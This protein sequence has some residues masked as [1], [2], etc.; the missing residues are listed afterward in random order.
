MF[1]VGW[2]WRTLP[3]AFLLAATLP[4]REMLPLAA[5]CTGSRRLHA[6]LV[7]VLLLLL[8]GESLVL[9]PPFLH[10]LASLVIRKSS[11]WS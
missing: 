11:D 3:A 10:Q 4:V 9:F 2:C 7:F 8:I 5:R 6:T 1:V